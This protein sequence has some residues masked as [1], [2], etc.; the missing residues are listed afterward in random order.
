MGRPRKPPHMH[1]SRRLSRAGAEWTAG[2]VAYF[3]LI[4]VATK[5]LSPTLVAVSVALE[6]LCVS[7]IGICFFGYSL[8]PRDSRPKWPRLAAAHMNATAHCSRR[9]TRLLRAAL[10]AR[11]GWPRRLGAEG[12]LRPCSGACPIRLLAPM[13]PPGTLQARGGRLLLRGARGRQPGGHLLVRGGAA[14]T[15]RSLRRR[16]RLPQWR[17]GSGRALAEVDVS[18]V[19]P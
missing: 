19:A 10:W 11:E 8:R 6:P 7:A 5:H 15:P 16:A 13:S 14:A 2:A 3:E 17:R 9:S 12:R 1:A 18:G 4:G